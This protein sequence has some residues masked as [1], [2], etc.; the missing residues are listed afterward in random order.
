ML[1]LELF[2]YFLLRVSY[3]AQYQQALTPDIDDICLPSK[4]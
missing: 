3:L 1:R 2:P 4:I